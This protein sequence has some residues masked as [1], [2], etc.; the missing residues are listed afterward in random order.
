MR[1]KKPQCFGHW[2]WVTAVG[3]VSSAHAIFALGE[4]AIDA[5][6]SCAFCI[7]TTICELTYCNQ[8]LTAADDLNKLKTGICGIQDPDKFKNYLLLRSVFVSRPCGNR[9]LVRA[10]LSKVV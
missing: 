9:P 6:Y 5:S 2:L 10:T 4:G 7:E 3:L 8:Y 1:F